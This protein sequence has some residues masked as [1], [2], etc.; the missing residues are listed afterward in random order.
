MKQSSTIW[1]SS[2]GGSVSAEDMRSIIQRMQVGGSRASIDYIID[3]L[4]DEMLA[5]NY[6][7]SNQFSL[8]TVTP[9]ERWKDWL[10]VNDRIVLEAAAI[11]VEKFLVD[12]T[13]PTDAELTAFVEKTDDFGT[14]YKDR[15]SQPDFLPGGMELPSRHPGFRDPAQDRRA[16]HPRPTTTSFSPRSRTKLPTRKSRSTTRT[17]RTRCSSRRIP[18]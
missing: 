17:T 2:A 13:E 14:K 15:E 7:A 18:A 8:A 3:A 1:T 5:R 16:I 11:P 10:R 6:L 4:R 12:V 9:E